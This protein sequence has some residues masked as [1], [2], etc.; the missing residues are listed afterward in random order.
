MVSIKK[1]AQDI[2]LPD[3]FQSKRKLL[4]KGKLPV[5]DIPISPQ[6][7]NPRSFYFRSSIG[8]DR[9]LFL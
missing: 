7:Q 4:S 6:L 8:N 9:N 2:Q 3:T 5:I 1:L